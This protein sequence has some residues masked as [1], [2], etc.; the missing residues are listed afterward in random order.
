[1]SILLKLELL[2]VLQWSFSSGPDLITRETQIDQRRWREPLCYS[3][4]SSDFHSAIVP[5]FL[6]K[7][8]LKPW[9]S[10]PASNIGF[11][12]R[13]FFF[14]I[15]GISQQYCL[16]EHEIP[17]VLFTETIS[18]WSFTFWLHNILLTVSL[19]FSQETWPTPKVKV[20]AR[21]GAPGLQTGPWTSLRYFLL[22]GL[23]HFPF[24]FT[25]FS[26]QLKK[27]FSFLSSAFCR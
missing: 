8:G 25:P 7:R 6:I 13:L 10:T 11:F 17:K 26:N 23:Q 24:C 9:R 18:F 2:L 15:L 4:P 16:P 5:L 22:R 12:C 1:M 20:W 3:Q 21:W 27:L 19:V 14:F